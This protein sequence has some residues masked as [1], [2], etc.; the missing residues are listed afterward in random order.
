M[1]GMSTPKLFPTPSHWY[2][3]KAIEKCIALRNLL[4]ETFSKYDHVAP[5]GGVGRYEDRRAILEL[6]ERGHWSTARHK[7]DLG[8]AGI[9]REE[10]DRLLGAIALLE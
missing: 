2:N 3:R 5:I 6:A 10:V 7:L 4:E 8:Q 1:S 9:P